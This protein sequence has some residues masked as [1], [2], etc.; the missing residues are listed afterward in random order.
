MMRVKT[1]FFSAL[2]SISLVPPENIFLIIAIVFGLLHAVLTPPFQSP[3]EYIHFYRSYHLSQGNLGGEKAFLP[4]DVMDFSREVNRDLPGNDQN[5][6][7]KK[8]L[9]AEFSRHFKPTPMEAADITNIAVYAP[10]PYIPQALGI[11]VGH[12]AHLPPIFI[13]YLGR[14]VNLSTWI[15]LVYLA[16]RLMPFHKRLLLGL[17]LLPMSVFIAASFSP[18]AL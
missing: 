7:S 15:A 11:F 8:A 16:I 13:F 1:K 14:L 4:K 9:V 5:K 12:Q 18:D 2:R 3:D 17:S 10:I 6:Q